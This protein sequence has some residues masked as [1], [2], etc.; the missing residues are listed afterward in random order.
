MP[1][2]NLIKVA[3]VF[4]LVLLYSYVAT[5]STWPQLD[6]IPCSYQSIESKYNSLI[7]SILPTLLGSTL[8]LQ[9]Q[10]VFVWHRFLKWKNRFSITC[11]QCYWIYSSNWSIK[12]KKTS[13][14]TYSCFNIILCGQILADNRIKSG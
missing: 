9:L 6:I 4:A 11:S 2:D 12:V 1:N 14:S 5:N 7:L 10:G 13:L 3:C 8:C